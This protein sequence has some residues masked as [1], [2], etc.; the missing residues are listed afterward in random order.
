[1]SSAS[2]SSSLSAPVDVT[3]SVLSSKPKLA[4]PPRPKKEFVL[5]DVWDGEAADVDWV[6]EQV[7][8]ASVLSLRGNLRSLYGTS[9]TAVAASFLDNLLV[10]R[11]AQD[12]VQ[13]VIDLIVS[14]LCAFTVSRDVVDLYEALCR[15]GMWRSFEITGTRVADPK[16]PVSQ[17]VRTSTMNATALNIM[18]HIVAYNATSKSALKRKVEEV[19]TIFSPVQGVSEFAK[20]TYEASK[21]VTLADRAAM[22]NVGKHGRVI[23]DAVCQILNQESIDM[24]K[25]IAMLERVSIKKF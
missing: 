15:D 8:A 17:W 13:L 21:D 5:P 23:I 11:V 9:I 2:A 14:V 6:V 20:L 10:A 7:P 24:T 19:G 16:K 1:M 22:E 18:G 12:P 3:S 25:T 4:T